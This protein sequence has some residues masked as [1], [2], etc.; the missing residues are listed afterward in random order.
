MEQNKFEKII[1]ELKADHLKEFD[2]IISKLQEYRNE[3]VNMNNET[4][5]KECINYNFD[6]FSVSNRNFINYKWRIANDNGIFKLINE[7]TTEQNK[8]F[9]CWNKIKYSNNLD[10]TKDEKENESE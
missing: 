4:F 1:A 10:I 2:T 5:I 7:E 9:D 8:M 6:S 3:V